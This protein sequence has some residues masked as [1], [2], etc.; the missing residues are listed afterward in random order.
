MTGTFDS[1]QSL[2]DLT[3]YIDLKPFNSKIV[4]I[5]CDK[6][7]A[8]IQQIEAANNIYDLWNY[9]NHN[10]PS[11]RNL[12]IKNHCHSEKSKTTKILT[13]AQNQ[14]GIKHFELTSSF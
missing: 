5:H 9:F 4:P 8:R 2:S 10:I 1:L 3:Y 12:K 6:F 13:V 11:L 14:L 7:F